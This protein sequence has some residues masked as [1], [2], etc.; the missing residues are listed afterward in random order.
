[1]NS[2]GLV[3]SLISNT[4]TSPEIW[5][6]VTSRLP[7][8]ETAN[9][10]MVC[11]SPSTLMTSRSS[12]AGASEAIWLTARLAVNSRPPPGA[13]AM[14]CGRGKKTSYSSIVMSARWITP[15]RC[16]GL[17]AAIERPT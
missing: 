7:S 11:V 4:M 2:R 13:A 8:G 14:A 3:G 5:P 9:C 10:T 16:G 17:T 12:S 1:M 15:T 6:P